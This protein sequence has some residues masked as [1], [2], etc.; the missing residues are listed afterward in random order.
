MYTINSSYNGYLNVTYSLSTDI[1]T[2][3]VFI[4][5]VYKYSNNNNNNNNNN[6]SERLLTNHKTTYIAQPY[7]P[8]R[9]PDHKGYN[10][11]HNTQS[12]H[13]NTFLSP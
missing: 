3:I 7:R 4:H 1:E 2:I 10:D 12:L 8:L 6:N 5:V 13:C 9:G 11:I